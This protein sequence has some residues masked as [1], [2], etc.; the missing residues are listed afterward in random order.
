MASNVERRGNWHSWMNMRKPQANSGSPHTLRDVRST[1]KPEVAF[2]RWHLHTWQ[3]W[4]ES[5]LLCAVCERMCGEN[6]AHTHT[7]THTHTCTCGC[8]C[9]LGTHMCMYTAHK[10]LHVMCAWAPGR[11]WERRSLHGSR[12]WGWGWGG[13][14][15]R[16]ETP[17]RLGWRWCPSGTWSS[18][19]HS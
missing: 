14:A 8:C 18:R 11:T 13:L 12:G 19:D 2:L 7:H 5:N 1:P 17:L 10:C 4:R 6:S 9:G 16:H 3:R 15:D